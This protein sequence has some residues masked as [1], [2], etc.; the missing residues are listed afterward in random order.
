MSNVL[1]GFF[2]LFFSLEVQGIIT[3]EDDSDTVLA[4]FNKDKDFYRSYYRAIHYLYRC[5][6]AFTSSICDGSKWGVTADSTNTLNVSNDRILLH[7]SQKTVNIYSPIVGITINMDKTNVGNFFKC[8]KENEDIEWQDARLNNVI[9]RLNITDENVMKSETIDL[10][11]ND[12]LIEFTRIKSDRFT[13]LDPQD[14]RIGVIYKTVKGLPSPEG[15]VCD[16]YW[17]LKMYL[18]P[19]LDREELARKSEAEAEA[20]RWGFGMVKK[21]LGW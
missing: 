18:I 8:L 3:L 13:T 5:C 6:L 2:L 20:S 14:K 9:R 21:W 4:A 16:R 1:I 10:D 11:K 12:N 7:A 17:W 19:D 15:V